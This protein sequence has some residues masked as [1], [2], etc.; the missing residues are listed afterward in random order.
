MTV[1]RP[2][3]RSDPRALG[4]VLT[5][6]TALVLVG[7]ASA[8]ATGSDPEEAEPPVVSPEPS[9]TPTDMFHAG[10]CFIAPPGILDAVNQTLI[11]PDASVE[12]ANAWFDE[13]SDFWLIIGVIK[14][15]ASENVGG[16]WATTTDIASE[17]FEG[18]LIGLDGGAEMYS[19]VPMS[20]TETL[21]ARSRGPLSPD[22]KCENVLEEGSRK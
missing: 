22:L 10:N 17:P 6:V 19:T 4:I 15:P 18:D 12:Y 14:R 13:D 20:E 16:A 9:P 1:R 3:L 8:S 7:C 21:D 5:F 11:E 2:H